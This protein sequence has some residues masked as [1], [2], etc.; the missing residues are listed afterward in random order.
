PPGGPAPA[1]LALRDGHG[2]P[3]LRQGRADAAGGAFAALP[4]GAAR[5][6]P[7]RARA[8]GA[9]PAPFCRQR[10]AGTRGQHRPGPRPGP[11]RAL[12]VSAMARLHAPGPVPFPPPLSAAEAEVQRNLERHV[13]ALA[14]GIGE[15]NMCRPGSLDAAARYLRGA[16]QA[17]GFA[18][19]AQEFAVEGTPVVNL[20]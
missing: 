15:R 3:P 18:V 19:K 1:R 20:E 9:H 7:G 10:E 14:E 16:L 11:C 13:Q 8:V 4:P 6:A 5:A 17:L 2:A 12:A